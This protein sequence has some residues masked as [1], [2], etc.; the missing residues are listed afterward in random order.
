M[1]LRVTALV[2]LSQVPCP[3]QLV[4]F[5]RIDEANDRAH[6]H[7]RLLYPFVETDGLGHSLVQ[8]AQ[9]VLRGVWMMMMMMR[10]SRIRCTY[11]PRG[12]R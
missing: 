8:T 12:A 2:H 5:C 1:V 9:V 10:H 3:N 4:A 7:T 11:L 6:K